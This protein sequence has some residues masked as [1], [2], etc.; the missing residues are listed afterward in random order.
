VIRDGEPVLYLERGGKSLQTLPAFGSPAAAE[1]ALRALGAIVLDGR[2]RSLQ[3][4]RIDGEPVASSIHRELLEACGFRPSYRG[5][6]LR[7]SAG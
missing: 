5:Y 1:G 7:A 3:V 4:E 2:S 6:V